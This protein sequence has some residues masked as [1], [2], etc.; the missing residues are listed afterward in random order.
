MAISIVGELTADERNIIVMGAGPSHQLAPAA[1]ALGG[2][3]ATAEVVDGG[4]LRLPATWPTVVQLV[5][6]FGSI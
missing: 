2:L 1:A 6:T 4:A 5:R 3:T